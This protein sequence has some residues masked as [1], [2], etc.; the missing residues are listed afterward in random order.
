M[1]SGCWGWIQSRCQE[2]MLQRGATAVVSEGTWL[3]YLRI[4]SLGLAVLE[5]ANLF[6]FSSVH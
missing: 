1:E 3:L 2:A 5:D 4:L 6:M